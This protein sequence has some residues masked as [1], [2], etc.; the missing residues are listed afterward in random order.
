MTTA[1][2]IGRP[3]GVKDSKPRKQRSD[4]EGRT[5]EITLCL[6][7]DELRRFE[8]RRGLYIANPIR[9]AVLIRELAIGGLR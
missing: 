7:D 2:R 9:L 6:T 8:S 4:G 1:K 5:N 3:P